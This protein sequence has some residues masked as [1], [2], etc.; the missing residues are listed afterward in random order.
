MSEILK[1]FRMKIDALDKKLVALLVEREKIVHQVAKIKQEHDI[2]VV[3]PE[4]IEEI[5]NSV[6]AQ[7]VE[8][9]GTEEYIRR[10]YKL[11]IELSCELENNH[12]NKDS[13][14]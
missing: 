12:I 3:L 7:A 5:L 11:I 9:G 1:P 8:Q 4:R 13:K 2:P 6:S 14:A 10:I